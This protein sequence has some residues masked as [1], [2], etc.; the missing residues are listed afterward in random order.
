MRNFR[1]LNMR[2]QFSASIFAESFEKL[3]LIL[4]EIKYLDSPHNP[5]KGK[6]PLFHKLN[7]LAKRNTINSFWKFFE[8]YFQEYH[9]VRTIEF[10]SY[11][12]SFDKQHFLKELWNIS[13][14]LRKN[15]SSY[16]TFQRAYSGSKNPANGP[17]VSE[18]TA[19]FFTHFLMG[20]SVN[21]IISREFIHNYPFNLRIY[22]HNSFSMIELERLP[23]YPESLNLPHSSN[24]HNSSF[25]VI[26]KSNKIVRR[27][28]FEQQHFHSGLSILNYFGTILHEKYPKVGNKLSIEQEGL[29]IRMTITTPEGLKDSIEKTLKEYG[30]VI[31][32][33][34][35]PE[36]FLDTPIQVM[37]LKQKLEIVKMEQ[38]MTYQQLEFE[39][40]Q[41]KS[42]IITLNLKYAQLMDQ[43]G[44]A[45][46]NHGIQTKNQ[47]KLI[48]LLEEKSKP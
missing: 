11:I 15:F 45:M 22:Y 48:H 28:E 8:T 44:L 16:S 47:S 9:L 27:I 2:Y 14:D 6:F 10:Y 46:T 19:A 35:L 18:K 4:E 38:R 42:H 29:I 5:R 24:T 17:Y 23:F 20:T 34:I 36:E 1:N 32:G 43:L 21:E 3:N 37:Q 30:E 31:M 13:N 25:P 26:S 33:R 12:Q 7:Q 40:S 39:R 41:H